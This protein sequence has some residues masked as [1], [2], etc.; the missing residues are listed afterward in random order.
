MQEI[1]RQV[2]ERSADTLPRVHAANRTKHTSEVLAPEDLRTAKYNNT[3]DD[4]HACSPDPSCERRCQLP[5]YLPRGSVDGGRRCRYRPSS[6]LGVLPYDSLILSGP[7]AEI[8]LLA[9]MH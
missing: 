9:Y 8:R 2:R 1:P 6:I 5:I 7:G 3:T 4:R